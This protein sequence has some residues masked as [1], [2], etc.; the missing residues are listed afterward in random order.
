[1][2]DV[3][4]AGSPAATI[5]SASTTVVPPPRSSRAL[6]TARA[7]WRYTVVV[8]VLAVAAVVLAAL[9]LTWDNP[10]PYG[11]DGFWR[12]ARRRAVSVAVMALVAVCQGIATVTFQTVTANRIITPSIMGF[13]SLYVAVQTAAVYL[14]GVPGLTALQGNRPFLVQVVVMVVLAVSLFGWL[15][16]GPRRSDVTTMLL[17]GIVVGGGLRAVATF[18][19]RLLTPS[20]FD[21]LSARMFGSIANADDSYLPVAVPLVAVA[22]G[23]LLLRA[24]RLNVLALGRDTSLR[25]GLDHRRELMVVLFLVSTLMA[26]STALIGPMTFFGFLT[27]AVAYQL[28]DTYDHRLVLPVAALTGFVVMSGAYFVLR[29]VVST[30]GFVSI[31]IEVV[32]GTAFL[33]ILLRRK[34]L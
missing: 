4:T 14:F 10:M 20:E 1:M 18:M 34:H 31:I 33:V 21:I 27:A 6:P 15:L 17:V 5:G 12:I 11:T 25:L 19:Q 28:A 9:L 23:A 16:S 32:G 13:E 24:R 3:T 29:H 22:A 8:A 7:R 2:A 26:V 30:Q